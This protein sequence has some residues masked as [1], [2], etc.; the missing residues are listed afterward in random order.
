MR[1]LFDVSMLIA[2]LQPDHV[3]HEAAHQWWSANASEGWA[4]CP[5]TQ[6]GFVRIKPLARIV[7][8][9]KCHLTEEAR[10]RAVVA[11]GLDHAQSLV[12]RAVGTAAVVLPAAPRTK[13]N[14][15]LEE[16]AP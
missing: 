7:V 2:L 12:V 1:S 4:S 13:L 5:L 9:Q 15:T 14:L 11:C 16:H 8:R 3:H 10:V 6:N